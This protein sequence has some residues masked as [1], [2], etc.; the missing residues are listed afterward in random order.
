[1]FER[2]QRIYDEQQASALENI[3]TLAEQLESVSVAKETERSLKIDVQEQNKELR[4][5]I[6]KYR[7]NMEH[8][9]NQVSSIERIKEN[10]MMGI[11]QTNKEL[12]K[13]LAEKNR[14][15][16]KRQKENDELVHQLDSLSSQQ[17]RRF[18]DETNVMKIRLHEMEKQ[19]KELDSLN[20]SNDVRL[21]MLVEQLKEKYNLQIITIEGKLKNEME[22]N[23]TLLA[24]SR[25][26]HLFSLSLLFIIGNLFNFFRFSII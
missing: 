22:R 12:S 6:D 16:L 21:Q 7:A 23:R 18:H 8:S 26:V 2:L 11:K 4:L 20:Q 1:M 13:E 24:K 10:E 5:I 17:E 15:L 9:K 14:L 25:F 3:K 19:N